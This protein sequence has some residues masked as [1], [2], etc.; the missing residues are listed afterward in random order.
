MRQLFIYWRVV[1][2]RQA[3]AQQAVQAMQAEL[4]TSHPGL[5]ARLFTREAGAE[6]TL[7]ETYALAPQGIDPALQARIEQRARAL[8]AL[9]AGARHVEVFEEVE[10]RP[11]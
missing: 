5:E 8:A 11:A 6:P 10:G 3:A 4:R 9:A 7:M 1:P 2:G